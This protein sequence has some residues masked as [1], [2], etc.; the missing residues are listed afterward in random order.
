MLPKPLV[1]FLT[2]NL[3]W[4]TTL[5]PAVEMTA[6]STPASFAYVLQADALGETPAIVAEKLKQAQRDWVVLD[7]HFSEDVDWTTSDL[8]QVRSGSPQRKVL[9]Y[10][11]IGEAENYRPYW[12]KIWLKNGKPTAQ[13]P[14][15]L[16]QE[17]PEWR[18]NYLVKYWDKD[19]QKIILHSIQEAMAVGFDG[20]YLDIVDGFETFE[21]VGEDYDEGRLNP[22]T[23]QSYRRDMI[24]WVKKV[25]AQARATK[26]DALVIPQNGSALLESDDFLSHISGI[27][28]EDLYTVGDKKQP[29]RDTREVL[30]NLQRILETKKP[31][32]LIEYPQK[33]EL[34]AYV[35]KRA[36]DDGLTLLLTDRELKTLGTS[37]R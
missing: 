1:L 8:N 11:S 25:S 5:L 33:S 31:V 7:P 26:P 37:Y 18:G 34:Q 6:T 15:W 21:K 10:I 9:A 4:G 14:T 20:V 35:K 13:A 12:Q 22:E 29:G 19:W 23:K 3:G 28:I 30:G 32:L 16:R 17:N 24:E 2:L 36:H 27:G